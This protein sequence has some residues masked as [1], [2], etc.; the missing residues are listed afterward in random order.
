MNA[1]VVHEAKLTGRIQGVDIDTQVHGLLGAYSVLDLLDDAVNTNLVD[2][3][4]LNDLETA[5]AV[6]VVVGGARQRGADTGVDV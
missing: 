5:V 1:V 4:R 2:L 3:A 6:V